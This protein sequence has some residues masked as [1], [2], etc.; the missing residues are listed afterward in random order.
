M[1]ILVV[2]ILFII[3]VILLL[4]SDF[5][6]L[7]S[8]FGLVALALCI[9][10]CNSGVKTISSI[11][12]ENKVIISEE[13]TTTYEL[14]PLDFAVYEKDPELSAKN[15]SQYIHIGDKGVFTFCYKTVQNGVEGFVPGSIYSTNAF[16]P[17]SYVG[18][19]KILEITTVYKHQLS[20]FQ[21]IW[22]FGLGL[23][24]E[25]KAIAYEICIPENPTFSYEQ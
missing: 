22:L 2:I 14:V 6:C 24:K 19:P 21:K 4:E 16:F 3:G 9:A 12:A 17:S 13:V 20:V 8:I 1:G 5:G 11:K 23:G 15:A 10:I 7:A 18:K 25:K